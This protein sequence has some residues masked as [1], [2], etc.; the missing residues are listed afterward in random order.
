M[1]RVV[2]EPGQPV[3]QIHKRVEFFAPISSPTFCGSCHDVT[4]FNGF[5]LEEA[6]SEYR[7]SPAARR[8]ISCQDCHMGK[9]QGVVSGYNEGPAAIIGGVETRPR[10]LTSHFF[11]GPDYSVIHPAIF[12]HNT[13]AQQMATIEEWLQFDHKAGWGT[14]AFEQDVPRHSAFPERWR[15]VDD[16]Y[17]AREILNQQFERLEWAKT[18]RLEV[19]RNGYHIGEIKV[20]RADRRGIRFKVEVKNATDG[21]NAP[22]GFTGERL[23]WLHVIVTDQEGTVIVTSGDLDPN[24]DLRDQESQYVHSG[25]LPLD[26]QLFNLQSRFLVTNVRGGERLRV[27]PIPYPVTALPRVLPAAISLVLTGEPLTERNHKKGIEPL[28]HRW[29]KYRIRQSALTGHGPYTA[30]IELKSAMVPANLIHAIQDVGFD[31]GMSAR[32]VADAVGAGHVILWDRTVTFNVD[33]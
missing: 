26:R 5:R 9:V 24:G 12:P 14:A 21:H 20:L 28:G 4:L 11:G 32:E 1:Y 16:R 22:T 17:D 7:V 3:R 18:K 25:E 6:F 30:T 13:E 19:L 23:I 15:S 8:G 10:K 29:A 2:T 33:G 27:I 31:Y